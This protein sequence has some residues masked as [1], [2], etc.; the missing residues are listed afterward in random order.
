MKKKL[1][2]IIVGLF[3]YFI[4]TQVAFAEQPTVFLNDSQLYFDVPPLVE[5][6]RTLV[7]LRTIF[8][9]LGA[10]VKWD[11]VTRTVIASKGNTVIKITINSTKVLKNG[12]VFKIDV[13]AKVING[14]TL[15]PLRFVSEALGANVNWDKNTNIITII[16]GNIN[17]VS[18]ANYSKHIGKWLGIIEGKN[19]GFI[20]QEDGTMTLILNDKEYGLRYEVD[21]SKSPIWLDFVYDNGERFFLIIKFNGSNEMQVQISG[22]KTRPT[23]F[24]KDAIVTKRIE[25]PDSGKIDGSTYSNKYF[26]LKLEIPEGWEVANSETNDRLYEIGKKLYNEPIVDVFDIID[27]LTISKYP[28]G[29]AV[30]SNPLFGATAENVKGIAGIKTGKDYLESCKQ[31]FKNMKIEYEFE[32][33]IYTEVIGNKSFDVLELKINVGSRKTYQKLYCVLIKDY[34]I[35]IS[36]TYT[37]EDEL[38]ELNKILNTIKF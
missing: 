25:V 7:P 22:N 30:Y 13:P 21:Y 34:A 10:N 18:E 16:S 12:A 19:G 15:V 8:E 1:F 33:E 27:L 26:G 20:F 32:K 35:L 14:R 5:K 37:S 31:I 38:K 3:A 6:G 29:A 4:A 23:K 2:T 17:E 9:E 24:G 36:L 28:V 11:E